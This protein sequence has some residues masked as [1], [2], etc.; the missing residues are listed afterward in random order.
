V[1]D[2]TALVVGDHGVIG[3]SV[4]E[5]LAAR[6]NWS[7]VGLSRRGAGTA[8]GIRHISVDLLD[9]KDCQQKLRDLG[10]ITQVIFCGIHRTPNRPGT[11]RDK[12]G[13]AAEFLGRHGAIC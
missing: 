11:R 12:F 1:S 8:A 7:V 13:A 9:R 4:A 5:H 10:Q 6:P 3:R 2:N